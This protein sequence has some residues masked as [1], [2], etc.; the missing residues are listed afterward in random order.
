MGDENELIQKVKEDGDNK[1]FEILKERHSGM[2]VKVMNRYAKVLETIGVQVE[3]LYNDKDFL[4]FDCIRKFNPSKKIKFVTF[5]ANWTRF[6]CL[7]KINANNQYV[8]VGDEALT[9]TIELGSNNCDLDK[10]NL[11]NYAD[12]INNILNQFSDKRIA[13]IFNMRYFN[14]EGKNTPWRIIAK[15]INLSIPA[16]ISL[17]SKAKELV[18]RKINSN[19]LIDT[20]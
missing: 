16:T 15:K 1:A 5:L 3:D 6:H 10:K 14:T 7:N 12:Y 11:K 17:H 4:I 19:G 8:A 18:Y 13:T 20:V 2:C 9:E